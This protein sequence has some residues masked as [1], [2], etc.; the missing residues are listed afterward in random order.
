MAIVGVINDEPHPIGGPEEQVSLFSIQSKANELH[1]ADA[2][3][4]ALAGGEDAG[5]FVPSISKKIALPLLT[6]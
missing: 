4:V 5:R 6:P 1:C 2:F 3:L